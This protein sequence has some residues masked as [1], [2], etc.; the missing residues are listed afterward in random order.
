MTLPKQTTVEGAGFLIKNILTRTSTDPVQSRMLSNTS[1]HDERMPFPTQ[2]S[3]NSEEMEYDCEITFAET[4]ETNRKVE[5][6]QAFL[7]QQYSFPMIQSENHKTWR[8]GVRDPSKTEDFD[9]E[10]MFPAAFRDVSEEELNGVSRLSQMSDLCDL[11]P[12]QDG[13]TLLHL[14][15]L[16]NTPAAHLAEMIQLLGLQDHVDNVNHLQQTPL[17][18][19]LLTD[20][21][22]AL[23]ILLRGL[24][25]SITIQDAHGN[26]PLHIA[27]LR[28]DLRAVK[29]LCSLEEE[30]HLDVKADR[31]GEVEGEDEAGTFRKRGRKRRRKEEVKSALEMKNY[32][33]F[34]CL[35]LAVQ[36]E[37]AELVAFLLQNGADVNAKEAKGGRTA[38]HMTVD[39]L[40]PCVN[41]FTLLL[42]HPHLHLNAKNYAQQTALQLA[43]GRGHPHLVDLLYAHGA[44][45]SDIC[46]SSYG[47][48]ADED[49][50]KMMYDD[51]CIAGQPVPQTHC[52]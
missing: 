24:K 22:P 46:H 35:H 13:D 15:V 9:A 7:R 17:H 3:S 11:F 29:I 26:T 37:N 34:T 44:D 50:L 1:S 5:Q 43:R 4:G 38:L 36:N 52:G 32:D 12:D 19:A 47:G 20:N 14:A 2:V 6:K 45:W 49:D 28:N 30:P 27:C 10:N 42:L 23:G 41:I 33:G 25:A 8:T 40:V 18:L 21:L 51:L 31:L 16:H 48:D 39:A